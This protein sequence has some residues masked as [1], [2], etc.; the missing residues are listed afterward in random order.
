MGE[1]KIIE[2]LTKFPLE[3]E[4]DD[5]EAPVPVRDGVGIWKLFYWFIDWFFLNSSCYIHKT[6]ID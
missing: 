3:A 4:P 2:K 6:V 1:K 5:W